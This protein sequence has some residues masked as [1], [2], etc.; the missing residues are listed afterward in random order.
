M[1]IKLGDLSVR[2]QAEI[3]KKYNYCGDCPLYKHSNNL[4]RCSPFGWRNLEEEVE[5]DDLLS[6]ESVKSEEIQITKPGDLSKTYPYKCDFC[7]CEFKLTLKYFISHKDSYPQS[8]N[9]DCPCC[10][11]KAFSKDEPSI[12][13]H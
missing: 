12:E 7:G 6:G 1:K 3:C 10:G 2:Q 9:Q 5:I 11:Q 8:L 13:I 4:G